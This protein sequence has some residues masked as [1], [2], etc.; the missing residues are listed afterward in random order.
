MGEQNRRLKI[1]NIKPPETKPADTK[2]EESNEYWRIRGWF[3]KLSGVIEE[4]LRFFQKDLI[5][6]NG[7]MNLISPRTERTCDLIHIADGIIGGEVVAKQLKATEIY[8]LGSGNGI[9]GLVFALTHPGIKVNLVEADGRKVEFLKLCVGRM[10]LSNCAVV[11]ARLEDLSPGVVKAAMSR[12]LA[13]VSKALLLA[14]RSASE[15]CQYFH[16]KGQ[17]WSRELADIPPQILSSWEP[18]GVEQYQLPENGPE[19]CIVLTVRN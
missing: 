17:G 13:N 14:R 3:P 9:P 7:K 19:M 8:D 6:F 18:A 12:G 2:P 1:L 4:K 15:G 5:H 11:H 16:F 10:S